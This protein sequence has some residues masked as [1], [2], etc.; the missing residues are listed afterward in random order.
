MNVLLFVTGVIML[1]VGIL[2]KRYLY[3][4]YSRN[5]LPEKSRGKRIYDRGYKKTRHMQSI[6][7]RITDFHGYNKSSSDKS[8]IGNQEETDYR[9][10]RDR[11]NM[12]E[13]KTDSVIDNRQEIKDFKNILNQSRRRQDLS[14]LPEK[15]REVIALSEK[16][17][18][19]DEIARE[20][21][22]GVRETRLILKFHREKADING[23]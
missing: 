8:D 21:D 9:K 11:K 14:Q 18:N 23:R 15:Y 1:V 3:R 22:L 5:S 6:N 2:Q 17:K 4:K 10:N 12:D 19:A 16:H 7:N 13:A 20:L